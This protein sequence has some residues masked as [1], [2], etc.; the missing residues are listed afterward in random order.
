M[1]RRSAILVVAAALLA[2]IVPST[3][4]LA[5]G[6]NN[7]VIASTSSDAATS[8]RSN[9]QTAPFGGD[10]LTSTN[11]ADAESHDCSG[12][13]SVAVAVQAV[14]NVGQASTFEP[15]NIASAVNA[16]CVSCT[17]FAYAYQY[18]VTPRGPVTLTRAGR[19]KIAALRAE[20]ADAADSG[21]PPDQLDA[22]LDT[23]TAEFKADIDHELR[24]AGYQAG[25][26]RRKQ[27]EIAPGG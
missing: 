19:V 22:R 14:F 1:R 8:A 10:T 24:A 12:C 21:L 15:A 2:T 25:G 20:I 13:H 9:L 16:N 23:L 26:D 17:S 5:G 3:P 27:V 11:I 18:V 7:I 4:A 6:A